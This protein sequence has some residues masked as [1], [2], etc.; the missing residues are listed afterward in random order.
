MLGRRRATRAQD[1]RDAL[2]RLRRHGRR[3]SP[4]CGGR[5]PQDGL[6][7]RVGSHAG[8]SARRRQRPL[9]GER[10][11]RRRARADTAVERHRAAS[12]VAD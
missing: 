11:L 7:G 5:R 12:G 4:L 2:W 9:A 10:A 8:R 3:D 1:Q 6:R